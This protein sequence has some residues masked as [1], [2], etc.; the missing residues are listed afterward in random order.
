[1]QT[2]I[3][4]EIQTFIS[5]IHAFCDAILE[6]Q[7]K[8]GWGSLFCLKTKGMLCL[9]LSEK[10][11]S[12]LKSVLLGE[13]QRLNLSRFHIQ[14][15]SCYTWRK[16]QEMLHGKKKVH[17]SQEKHTTAES[18][19]RILNWERH[20]VLKIWVNITNNSTWT[21][22]DELAISGAG[23]G[24]ARTVFLLLELTRVAKVVMMGCEGSL[25]VFVH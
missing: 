16:V 14:S 4:I 1:M 9:Y 2:C 23:R 7:V 5:Q 15:E 10:R 22:G 11:E 19:F 24:M 18:N 17:K 25:S 6:S 21:W 8:L 13:I 20:L 3:S 12:P